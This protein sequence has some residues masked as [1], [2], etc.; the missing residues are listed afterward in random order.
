VRNAQRGFSLLELM[1]IVAIIG[2]LA[3]IVI[4]NWASTS[5][6]KKYDPEITAMFAEIGVREEQYKSE[7]G[8]GAY[9]PAATCPASPTPAGIDFNA[10]CVG[11]SGAWYDLRVNPTDSSIRCT[12]AVTTG[13]NG[14][15]P[16]APAPCTAAAATLT[17]SWYYIIA[18]CDMDGAGGTNATFCTSSWSNQQTNLNYGS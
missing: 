15:L 13:L 4:P 5:R 6:N 8:N 11:V 9:L 7:L 17:G 18:T 3:A 2:I 16:A 12:Y 1:I 14:T 10:L